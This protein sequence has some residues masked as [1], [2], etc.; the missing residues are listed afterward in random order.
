MNQTDIIVEENVGLVHKIAHKFIGRGVDYEDLVSIGNIGL[1]KAAKRFDENMNYKFSTY[2]FPLIMGEIKRYLRDNN[3]IKIPRKSRENLTKIRYSE[4]KLKNK[5][6]R[7]PTINEISSDCGIDVDDIL[8][9]LEDSYTTESLYETV[10]DDE[11]KIDKIKYDENE[12]DK[13][14]NK[15]LIKEILE[16]LDKRSRQ[17]IV[18]RYFKEETQQSIADK[19]GISQVQVSRIEKKVLLQLREK[20]KM[21]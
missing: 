16:T 6:G 12:F 13:L 18:L 9:A 10:N 7:K 14:D 3:I 20:I 1:I 5:L 11:Y 19:L 4:E 21:L 15:I 17:V 2:A 8:E